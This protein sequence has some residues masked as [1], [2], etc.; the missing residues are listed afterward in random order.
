MS[1]DVDRTDYY[2]FL[3][4]KLKA[5]QYQRFPISQIIDAYNESKQITIM[6]LDKQLIIEIFKEDEAAKKSLR[7]KIDYVNDLENIIRVGL[8]E[9]IN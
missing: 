1:N 5:V 7:N 8:L 3:I 6:F 9:S 4:S 2:D